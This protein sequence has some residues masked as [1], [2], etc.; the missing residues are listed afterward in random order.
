MRLSP[1][2]LRNRLTLAFVSLATVPLFVAMLVVALYGGT[3]HVSFSFNH[4]KVV[5]AQV[6]VETRAFFEKIEEELRALNRFAPLARLSYRDRYERLSLLI[7]NGGTF[8]DVAYVSPSGLELARVSNRQVFGPFDLRT[9]FGNQDFMAA[10]ADRRGRVTPV[11]FDPETGEPHITYFLPLLDP[12]TDAVEGLI[13]AVAGL[14][15][16]WDMIA[17]MEANGSRDIYVLDDR[18]RVIAHG[19]PTVVL[20]DTRFSFVDEET[21][22]RGLDHRWAV[23]AATEIPVGQRTF[24]VVAEVGAVEALSAL[25]SNMAVLIAALITALIAGLLFTIL[26]RRQVLEP[27]V[28]VTRAAESLRQGDF[29]AAVP[30]QGTEEAD[31]MA[32]A[33]NR[34]IRQLRGAV[35]HLETER[36]LLRSLIDS[37]PD[38]IF[39]KDPGLRFINCNQ[40]FVERVG[41]SREELIGK[42]AQDLFPPQ[43]AEEYQRSDRQVLDSGEM[44][45]IEEKAPL[46]DGT[47]RYFDT[48]KLPFHDRNG[49][50]LGIIGVAREITDRKRMEQNLKDKTAELERSNA[51]LDRFA[52]AVSHDLQE[53]LRV[54]GQYVAL[55][56]RR[57]ADRL[58]EDGREFCGFAVDGA[59]RMQRMIL[60]LL[61][62]SRV[63]SAIE[64]LRPVDAGGALERALANL[65]VAIETSEAE[66][67]TMPLPTVMADESQ[68]V[69]VF[70]NLIGNAVKYR[71]PDRKPVISVTT[72]RRDGWWD[73]AIRDNGLGINA[74]DTERIFGLFQRL[75]PHGGPDG[76]GIGLALTKRIVE[77]FE[78]SIGVESEQGVGTTFTVSLRAPPVE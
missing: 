3:R 56:D 57:Y 67:S 24:R 50:V 40:A 41:R 76:S 53:P 66:L 69:R 21:V 44:R 64:A 68:L 19:N 62:Y 31:I 38:I 70:Q 37:I 42:V 39:I 17:A 12:K 71:H 15:P 75:D 77:C 13:V 73:I 34:M 7:F 60:D 47:A 6:A 55:I 36:A 35:S 72:E 23:I 4:Q 46:P 54:V 25:L 20:R 52:Y 9:H 43:E 45:R 51:E 48:F 14:K 22:Q 33:F 63:H 58:D 10:L 18:D 28:S 16:M 27:I 49:Q 26:A 30:R 74:E 61:E 5:S 78:G 1:A 29:H 11:L 59:R 2:S 32:D 65:E 8:R